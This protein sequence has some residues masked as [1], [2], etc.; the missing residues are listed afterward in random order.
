MVVHALGSGARIACGRI[1]MKTAVDQ[2]GLE[3]D[4]FVVYPG[5]VGK[6]HVSGTLKIEGASGSSKT[7]TQTLTWNLKGLDTACKA[8]AADRVKNGC[9]I[10]VHHGSSCKS[11]DDVG[12]HYFSGALSTDPWA[13]VRY[14][15]GAD[16]TSV[17]TTGVNVVTG[18]SNGDITG[19]VMVVHELESGRRI[20]CGVIKMA[21]PPSYQG[22]VFVPKFVKYP[23]Y[24]GALEV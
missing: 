10:H 2:P 5:Y 14:V 24:A 9:G 20:A 17:Q 12:G 13:G 18:N 11:A 21:P 6:L 1:G 19:R 8:G 22:T 15:A 4:R 16:G 3:V 23:G 7:A